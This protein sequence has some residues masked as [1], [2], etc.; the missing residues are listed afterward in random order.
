MDEHE[1]TEYV[2]ADAAAA[3]PCVICGTDINTLADADRCPT[4]AAPVERS[5]PGDALED[6]SPEYVDSLAS[7][8]FLI[9]ASVVIV[10]IVSIAQQVLSFG[11]VFVPGAGSPIELLFHGLNFVGGILSFIGWWKFSAADPEL[12]GIYNGNKLRTFIRVTVALQ[13]LLS[14][15]AMAI[16]L[17]APASFTPPPNSAMPP[18]GLVVLGL[19]NLALSAVW[20][21][22]SMFYVRWLAPRI[23]NAKVYK[24]AKTL[25][26]LGPV[27]T[28]PGACILVGPLIAIAL[29]W[30]MIYW[31]WKDLKV[32][33]DRQKGLD[34]LSPA[35]A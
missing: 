25:L 14:L 1:T 27:L 18:I 12:S 26:W 9:L 33:E 29:Y 20:F 31:V 19:A 35:N 24:R 5:F 3:L 4:C 15:C 7:G 2:Q 10:L 8:A 23:P 34:R 11:G 22:A 17:A 30:N 21:F 28:I 6:S 16:L 13:M 32:I